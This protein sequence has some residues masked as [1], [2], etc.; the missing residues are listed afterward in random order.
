MNTITK[1]KDKKLVVESTPM[2]L[3]MPRWPKWRIEEM[4]G[5]VPKTTFWDDFWIAVYFG[6]EEGVRD[7]YNRAFKEWRG[8]VVYVT[9][10][11]LVLNWMIWVLYEV[12]EAMARVFDELWR[13]ADEWCREHL[14][15]DDREYYYRVTD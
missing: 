3:Q 15:G 13:E 7:T 14:E 12:D 8:D 2:V 6:G 5:Y 11:V 10:L 4:C 1:K 9:E